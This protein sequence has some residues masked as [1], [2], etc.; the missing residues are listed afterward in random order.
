MVDALALRRLLP[1]VAAA[2]KASRLV[3]TAAALSSLSEVGIG[4]ASYALSYLRST[5]PLEPSLAAAV[6]PG[7]F[8]ESLQGVVSGLL[9]DRPTQANAVRALAEMV[10]QAEGSRAQAVGMADELW[11]A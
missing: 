6:R 4:A 7:T 10:D 2:V 1:G 11:K 9:Q 8:S 5:A 3:A